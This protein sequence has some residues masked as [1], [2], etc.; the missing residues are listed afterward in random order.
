M[1]AP[2]MLFYR[3]GMHI[4]ACPVGCF[5]A[6]LTPVSSTRIVKLAQRVPAFVAWLRC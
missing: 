4:P 3:Q 5:A 1:A 6:E 2:A